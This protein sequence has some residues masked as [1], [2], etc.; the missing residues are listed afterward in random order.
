MIIHLRQ[1]QEKSIRIF[2]D[3]NVTAANTRD[4]NFGIRLNK[5]MV[6]YLKNLCLTEN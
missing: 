5:K 1:K 2:V 3:S 4:T 6:L